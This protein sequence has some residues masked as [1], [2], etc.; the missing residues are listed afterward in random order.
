MIADFRDLA[1]ASRAAGE[2]GLV[3]GAIIASV[4]MLVF[5]AAALMAP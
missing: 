4:A 1:A 2:L 3:H 5:T